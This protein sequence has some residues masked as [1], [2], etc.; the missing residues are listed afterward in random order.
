MNPQ[1]KMPLLLL[2]DG[3]TLPESE[4]RPSTITPRAT[5]LHRALIAGR[6]EERRP[7][8]APPQTPL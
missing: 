8:S 7:Q 4:V 3:T 6:Q 2:P 5:G 1:G